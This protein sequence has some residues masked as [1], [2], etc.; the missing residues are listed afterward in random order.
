MTEFE[1]HTKDTAPSESLPLIDISIAAYGFHPKLHQIMAEAPATY[2]AYLETFRLF[3]EETTLSPLEQH[4][5][6]QTANYENRCHYCTAG[7]SML[8]QLIKA[9]ADITFTSTEVQMLTPTTGHLFGDLEILGVAA[10]VELD[11]E[12]VN[13]RHYPSFIPN[14]DEVEVVG[15]HATGDVKRLDHGLDFIAFLGSP[16]GLEV[17]LDA[18]FDLVRCDGAADTNVPCNWGR[19]EG[20]KGPSE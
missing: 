10:P 8:M 1:Y 19:V 15:F 17:T 11:F 12:M 16:T 3:A 13:R 14:Y 20:F 2:S 7:H 5:V 4:I 9:Y 6:M 18:R